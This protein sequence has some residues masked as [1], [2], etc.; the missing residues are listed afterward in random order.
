MEISY[1]WKQSFINL[2]TVFKKLEVANQLID[3]YESRVEELKQIINNHQHSDLSA[4]YFEVYFGSTL[5]ALSD[6]F[7]GEILNEVGLQPPPAQPHTVLGL[8]RISEETLPKIASDILFIGA[9]KK[10]D[11][12][13]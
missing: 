9:Y 7:P 6:S 2:A 10:D 1:S 12:A 5:L 11:K 4:S 8:L 3:K 13:L